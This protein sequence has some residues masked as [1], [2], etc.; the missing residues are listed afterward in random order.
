MAARVRVRLTMGELNRPGGLIHDWVR[1]IG[2][3]MR[4]FSRAEVISTTGVAW[5]S[6]GRLAA[7]IGFDLKGS[8][9]FGITWNVTADAEYA[10]FVHEG[11]QGWIHAR[12]YKPMPVGA[13]QG[14][15]R[16]FA[17]TVAGQDANP[18]LV[19]GV[20]TALVRHRL[21]PM[22]GGLG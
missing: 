8:N 21:S 1:E 9:Q 13:T 2:A 10:R 5:G 14:N 6:T 12:G 17:E 15:V 11:T 4:E 19:R 18:F 7:S 16:T 22:R 3:E 20:S